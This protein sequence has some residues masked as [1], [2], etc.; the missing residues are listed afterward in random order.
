MR[1]RSLIVLF[2]VAFVT[3]SVV[4]AANDYVLVAGGPRM[5]RRIGPFHYLRNL[6]RYEAALRTFGS[7]TSRK[8]DTSGGETVCA[9]R[10]TR[11]GLRM[12]FATKSAT[13]CSDSALSGSTWAGARLD[14]GPWR[15]DRGLRLGD[16]VEKLRRLYSNAM[17]RSRPTPAVWL[18][19]YVRG[20]VGT[21]VLLQARVSHGRVIALQLP[22]PIVSV[23]R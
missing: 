1:A 19:L 7:E 11:L 20:E 8:L 9:V 5:E 21:T 10:W 16:R 22:P 18:L 17:Y 13:S 6:G 2:V 15:T 3:A 12:D 14:A 23:G 4:E